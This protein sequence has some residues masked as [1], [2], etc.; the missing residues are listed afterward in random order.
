MN[1]WKKLLLLLL[2]LILVSQAPFAYRRY[3]LGRLE[4][5]INQLNSRRSAN[6]EETDAEYVG[7]LHVHSFLG[8]HTGG[9][10]EEI[11]EGAKANRLDFVVM[12]EHPSRD[13]DSAALTLKGNYGGVLFV[14]GNEVA[15]ANRGRLLLVPGS[16]IAASGGSD[17][18][19]HFLAQLKPK[20][21]LAVVAY[22]QEFKSWSTSGYD[23]VE[24]YNLFTNARQI[25]PV[26]M[27]FDGLWSYRR[28]PELLFARFYERPT[29]N[30]ELWDQAML[31][32]GRRLVA[33]AGND[34]HANVGLSLNDSS[35]K[36][37]LGIQL[38]PYE[39]SFRLVRMHVLIPSLAPASHPPLAAESLV[40]ALRAGH[41]FIAFDLFGDATGFR[42]LASNGIE[43][44]SQG[45]DVALT[46]STHLIVSTP[47]ESRIRLFR[48]GSVLRDQSDVS[49]IEFE[50]TEKG[51]Y[52][53]EV[54]LPQLPKS[55]SDQPWIISNPIYVR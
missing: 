23:G 49:K 9:N 54:Y 16:E 13:F 17:T 52:R 5:L 19:D 31:E 51:I 21:A 22:P 46:N 41:C 40:D 45:D 18:V 34:A 4:T 15:F 38:D 50:V 39:R 43:S 53:V 42:F 36:K 37:L 48:N 33:V 30:L 7:V 29:R 14:N 47:L 24:V 2:L 10:F 8:G 3:Q 20:D 28:Y 35:G 27:F 6:T 12:T 25:N 11:I 26:M 44:R 32:S 55:L 1:V